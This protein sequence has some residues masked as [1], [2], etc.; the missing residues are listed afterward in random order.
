MHRNRA[1]IRICASLLRPLGLVASICLWAGAATPQENEAPAERQ[2]SPLAIEAVTIDPAQPGVDTLCQLHVRVKNTSET[3]ISALDFGVSIGGTPLKVYEKQLFLESLEPGKTADIRLYNFWTTETG[4][5]A[6]S[7]GQ[8]RLVV[9]LRGAQE[10]GITNEDDG[11]EVW[12][13]G[14]AVVGL[15]I[16]KELVVKLKK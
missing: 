11:T 3:T 5:P 6:P 16:S 1:A 7:D 12:T 4:R 10:V 14:D 2:P 9:T 15:P 8:L 13:L